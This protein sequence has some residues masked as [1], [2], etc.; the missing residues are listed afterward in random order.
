VMKR[1][2]HPS[3]TRERGNPFCVFNKTAAIL[4]STDETRPCRS[5]QNW[6]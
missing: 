5:E 2:S 1:G 6:S 3:P 4:K